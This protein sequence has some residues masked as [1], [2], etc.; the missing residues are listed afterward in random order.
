MRIINPCDIEGRC[1]NLWNMKICS[2][3]LIM[4]T[5]SQDTWYLIS[6]AGWI[7]HGIINGSNPVFD[8]SP[9][10]QSSPA[11]LPQHQASDDM[12]W[13]CCSPPRTC[14]SW[15]CWPGRGRGAVAV[16]VHLSLVYQGLLPPLADAQVE[17]LLGPRVQ[18]PA[19]LPRHG[20]QR[21][22]VF[23][24]RCLCGFLRTARGFPC[25]FCW[26]FVKVFIG[27]IFNFLINILLGIFS[28]I[29]PHCRCS[30]LKLRPWWGRR[31][32]RCHCKLQW[33]HLV[34]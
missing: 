9:L 16:P 29:F 13:H 24:F 12:T 1:R 25:I 27:F 30:S 18:R 20:L 2:W 17:G 8:L 31:E 21:L 14:L 32:R 23:W 19:A 6:M 7:G 5:S 11:S 4:K 28:F 33:K 3:G 10:R 22:L 15:T 26:G 34:R